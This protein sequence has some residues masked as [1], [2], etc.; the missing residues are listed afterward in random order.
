MLMLRI[1]L[2]IS[3]PNYVCLDFTSTFSFVLL[4]SDDGTSPSKCNQ[5]SIQIILQ[6]LRF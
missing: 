5:N 2:N 6:D 1:V 3:V 4:W